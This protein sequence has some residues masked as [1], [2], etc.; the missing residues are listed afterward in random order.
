MGRALEA[1]GGQEVGGD[2]MGH[3]AGQ[4][5]LRS[6]HRLCEGGTNIRRQTQVYCSDIAAEPRGPRNTAPTTAQ[7][8]LTSVSQY[9]WLHDMC[10]L[11]SAGEGALIVCHDF[12]FVS[13]VLLFPQLKG[14]PS[15]HD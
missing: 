1:E 4:F 13:K 12:T 7:S 10:L 8:A 9:Q 14:R 3:Q 11:M 6:S 5:G 15:Q 2:G